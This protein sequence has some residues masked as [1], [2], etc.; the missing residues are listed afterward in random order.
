MLFKYSIPAVNRG[1]AHK[2][3]L[4]SQSSW[5]RI[6]AA[7]SIP[8]FTA[9]NSI[10]QLSSRHS[11]HPSNHPIRFSSTTTVTVTKQT[12]QT[13]HIATLT[14]SNPTKPNILTPSTLT[15]LTTACQTLQTTTPNL[16]AVIL[17]GGPPPQG[18]SPAFIAG[19][20]I[21]SLQTLNSP[22]TAKAFITQIHQTC[23]ALRALPVPVLARIHGACLGAGLEIAA[24]CD[25]R[26]ATQ[27]SVFGMPEVRLGIPSVVEAAL[28]PGLIGMGRTRRLLYLAETLDAATAERWGLVERVVDDEMGLDEAVAEWVE[29]LEGMGPKALRSQKSLMQRWE[30]CSVDEGVE[31]GVEAFAAAFEDGGVEAREFMGR[32]GRR[33]G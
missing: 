11:S 12:S 22:A 15:A 24:A 21:T 19:A 13:G 16:R 18:K 20:D 14:L 28:L 10:P 1:A 27:T 3:K 8:P 5:R 29:R 30:N 32:F 6:R 4:S 33:R 2:A 23:Q 26:L 25:L 9:R 7:S 17:T 31:A